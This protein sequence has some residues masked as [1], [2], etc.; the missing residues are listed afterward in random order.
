[1]R[2]NNAFAK[3]LVVNF[4]CRASNPEGTA[5]SQHPDNVFVDR[6][7]IAFACDVFD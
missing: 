4:T 3:G 6:Q 7:H 5:N 2:S 1:M